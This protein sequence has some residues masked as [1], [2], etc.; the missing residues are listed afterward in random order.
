MIQNFLKDLYIMKSKYWLYMYQYFLPGEYVS[1][2]VI[3]SLPRE[4]LNV[5]TGDV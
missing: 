2:P 1:Q 5:W 4:Y 3:W